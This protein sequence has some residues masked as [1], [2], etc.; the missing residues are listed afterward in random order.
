LE[1]G[2]DLKGEGEFSRPQK[3]QGLLAIQGD[4]SKIIPGP[5]KEVC[6]IAHIRRSGYPLNSKIEHRM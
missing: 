5:R 4:C 6:A 1:G 2:R 3:L